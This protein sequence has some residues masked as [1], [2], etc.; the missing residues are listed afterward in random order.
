V[1]KS[2]EAKAEEILRRHDALKEIRTIHEPDWQ[3]ISELTHPRYSS[4]SIETPSIIR[5]KG[6]NSK[7]VKANKLMG[8]GFMGYMVSRTRPWFKLVT[9]DPALARYPGVADWLEEAESVLLAE[10]TK[11][12]F[13]DQIAELLPIMGSIGTGAVSMKEDPVTPRRAQ[14]ATRHPKEI[15]V[16]S[17]YGE[18]IDVVFRQFRM[19]QTTALARWRKDLPEETRER[20]ERKPYDYMQVLHAVLPRE[21]WMPG[22]PLS[23]EKRFGSFYVD[24]GTK[25]LITEGGFAEFPYLVGRW[26][27]NTDSPYGSSPGHDCLVDILR[28]Q[29]VSRTQMELAQ[30]IADPMIDAP[31]T[32]RDSIRIGAGAVNFHSRPEEHLQ[33]VQL[34]AN[35]P[36]TIEQERALEQSIDEHYN[37]DFFL[38]LSRMER[39]MTARE[40]LERKGEQAAVLGATIGAFESDVLSPVIEWMFARCAEWGKIPQPPRALI[41]SGMP[42]DVEYTGYLAQLQRKYFSSTGLQ[43]AMSVLFPIFQANPEAMDNINFDELARDTADTFNLSQRI[44]REEPEVQAMRQSRAQAQ[45]QAMQQQAAQEQTTQV[46]ASADKLGQ[47]PQEGSPLQQILAGMAGGQK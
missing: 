40:V 27:K 31:E 1:A 33:A 8:F 3:E 12:N 34:G 30:K 32:I 22:S 28:L 9:T 44:V 5:A 29:Q 36:I 18:R 7:G 23:I 38:M 41:E 42:I 24:M 17:T 19:M 15:W 43:D 14:F 4:W 20:C 11:S 2:D 26:T 25:K 21:D 6:F 37:V 45:Q 35:Y 16:A 39:E 13:Y 46:M 47:V 10:L